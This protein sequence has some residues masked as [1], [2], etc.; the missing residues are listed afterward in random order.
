MGKIII[1]LLVG[2]VLLGEWRT[3]KTLEGKN[4]PVRISPVPSH[5]RWIQIVGD[6]GNK[7]PVWFGDGSAGKGNGLPVDPGGW[8]LTP[9]CATCSYSVDKVF[10]WIASGD[11][12]FVAWGD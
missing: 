2:M 9:Q 1:G 6:K 12:V 3:G 8:Y 4:S 7:G 11:K 10:V 5:A